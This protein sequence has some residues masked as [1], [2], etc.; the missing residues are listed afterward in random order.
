[1]CIIE[2]KLN[3]MIIKI[4]KHK[5]IRKNKANTESL[6]TIDNSKITNTLTQHRFECERY[7]FFTEEINQIALGLNDD[8]ILQSI[9]SIET[10]AYGTCKYLFQYVK[11]KKLNVT[12]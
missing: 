8:K 10:Y 9:D 2:K 4:N 11:N 7:N 1:M 12:R 5:L 6:R 3:L